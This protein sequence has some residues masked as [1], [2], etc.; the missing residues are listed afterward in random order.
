M[1]LSYLFLSLASIYDKWYWFPLFNYFNF[2]FEPFKENIVTINYDN[3][4]ENNNS[5]NDHCS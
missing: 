1:F 4:A 3:D 2:K 5:K